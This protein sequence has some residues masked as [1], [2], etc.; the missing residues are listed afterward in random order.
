MTER[1][2]VYGAAGDPREKFGDALRDAR[3]TRKAGRI[4]QT[5]LG[6]LS[7]TSKSTISRIEGGV[8]PIAGNL[9]ALFDQIFET[10]GQFKRLYEDVVDQSY[11]AQYRRRMTLE[12]QA[13]AILEWSPTLIPGLFQTAEYARALFRCGYRRATEEN[14]AKMVRARLARQEVLR[15]EAPPTVRVVVCESVIRR[16]IGSHDMMREQLAVLLGHGERPTTRVQVMPLDAEPHPLTDG[17]ITL[18]TAPNHATTL[19]V[20]AYRT[21]NI[22]DDPDNVRAAVRAYDDLSS[23]ALSARESAALI[24]KQMETL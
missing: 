4:S 16:R 24:R 9:P 7:R 15:S 13:T 6:R 5:D 12:R 22:S 21:A 1:H 18:L 14:I 23:E 2:G 17:A 8:P 10:D 20:E 19:C 11:P 3:K